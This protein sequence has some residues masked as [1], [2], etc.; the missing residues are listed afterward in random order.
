LALELYP[1][2]LKALEE[3]KNGSVLNG[4]VGTGKSITAVAYYYLKVCR[5]GIRHNGFGDF[6]PMEDP[7]DLYIITTAKKRDKLEWEEECAPFNLS[8]KREFSISG[9]QVTVDSW[10]NI[11]NYKDVKNAFFI[12]DEQRAVGYGKWSK[13]LIHIAKK[14]QW[15][16]LSATPGD[17]W[18][19]Y[20]PLFIA[21]GFYKNK[22]EFTDQHVVWK[23]F[24]K[25]PS[26]DRYVDTGILNRHRRNITVNMP[27]PRHT[28]RH[29]KYVP[30]AYDE[31]RF[32]KVWKDRWH[33]YED[34]PLKDVSELFIVARKLVNSHVSRLRAISE[35]L[36]KHDRLIVF[37]NFNYELEDLRTLGRLHGI[38]SAEWN[39]HKHEEVPEDKRWLYLVQYTAGA[40]GWNCITTD[41]MA[42]FSLNYSYK[43]NHQSKGRIDRLNTKYVD[44]YYYILK[45]NSMIDKAILRSILEKKNF[46]EKAFLSGKYG[47]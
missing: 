41:A 46:N 8:T 4:D 21:N 13:A 40:E 6:K 45:S 2:Q 16:M 15:V 23:R 35:L 37:Y 17:T 28:V 25:F 36:D 5:G 3:M 9:V 44:L 22:T 43:L 10:N 11:D 39:G 19:D 26:I 33:I 24:S 14:N 42:F 30:V 27:Y 32:K 7:K 20:C 18:M 31:D 47:A 29:I 34:R 1:H 38:R 12:F